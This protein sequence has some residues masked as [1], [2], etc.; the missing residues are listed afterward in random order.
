MTGVT[1][2]L[3]AVVLECI[4]EAATMFTPLFVSRAAIDS[5]NNGVRDGFI[6]GFLSAFV[7]AVVAKAIKII[8]KNKTA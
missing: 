6:Y 7:L 3:R 1:T 8:A 4:L 5:Y 2:V